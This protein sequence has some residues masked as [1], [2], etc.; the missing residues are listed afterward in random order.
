MPTDLDKTTIEYT[1]IFGNEVFTPVDPIDESAD[2][3]CG[4]VAN[5]L[6]YVKGFIDYITR[7]GIIDEFYGEYLDRVVYYFTGIRRIPGEDDAYLRIRFKSL[8]HR[9]YN[10]SWITKWMIRDVFSYFVSEEGMYVIENY[11]ET[12]LITDPSFELNP[13]LNWTKYEPGSATII[14][15]TSEMFDG[16]KCAEMAMVSGSL[17]SLSQTVSSIVEGMHVLSFYTK[18]DGTFGG[19]IPLQVALQRSSD[20]YYYNF[21]TQEWQSATS[22]WLIAKNE[23]TRYEPQQAFVDI[24]LGMAGQDVTLFFHNVPGAPGSYSVYIDLVEFGSILPNPSVEVVIVG[25]ISTGEEYISIAEGT[26]DPIVGLDYDIASYLGHD[27]LSGFSGGS[28]TYFDELLQM[29]KPAGVQSR[30]RV[31][32]RSVV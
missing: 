25:G 15:N 13:A 3:N 26:V 20:S 28:I 4:A 16:G 27:F 24:P 21:T 30:V 31:V 14:W 12:N 7:S 23:S 18:D 32:E 2:F 19:T 9:R 10:P 22:Y 1:A 8:I 11:I 29:V 5:E 17:L 6:E